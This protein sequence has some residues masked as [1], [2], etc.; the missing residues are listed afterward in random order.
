RLMS[1][2]P[3]IMAMV[4]RSTAGTWNTWVTPYPLSM[5]ARH[6]APLIFRLCPSMVSLSGTKRNGISRRCRSSLDRQRVGWR[7]ARAGDRERRCNQHELVKLVGNAVVGEV[8]QI[9]N[10]AHGHAHDRDRDPVPGLVD[11]AF[12]VVRPPLGAPGVACE[13]RKLGASHPFE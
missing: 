13:R 7:T 8:F 2:R 12:G 11:A 10:L 6:S 3:S 1:V 5:S 9:E 4:L